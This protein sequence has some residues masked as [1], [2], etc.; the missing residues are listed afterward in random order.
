MEIPVPNPINAGWMVGYA[1][2]EGGYWYEGKRKGRR[3]V[4]G[5]NGAA[6]G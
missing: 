3:G 5:D 4:G 6:H 2:E 1:K